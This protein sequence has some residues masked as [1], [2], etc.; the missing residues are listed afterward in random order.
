MLS[1]KGWKW[2][3]EGVTAVINWMIA[4]EDMVDGCWKR[5]LGVCSC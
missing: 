1:G 4:S 2:T 5:I 3:G